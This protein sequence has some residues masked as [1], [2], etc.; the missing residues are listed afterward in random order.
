MSNNMNIDKN[1][2]TQI[3]KKKKFKKSLF[4]DNRKKIN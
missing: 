2:E 4:V 1:L 3:F